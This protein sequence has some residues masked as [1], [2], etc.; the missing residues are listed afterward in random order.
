[1]TKDCEGS[2]ERFVKITGHLKARILRKDGSI[3]KRDLG[4]NTITDAAIA[5][6][7]NDWYDASKELTNMNYHA[8]G[9]GACAE[10]VTCGTSA[11][12]NEGSE[13]RVAGVKSKPTA[14]Q[15]RT[16]ATITCA[17]SGKTIKEWGVFDQQAVGGTAWSLRCFA[18]APITVGV[19]DSIEF[20]YTVTFTCVQG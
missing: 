8:W 17:G 2:E 19:G 3:E 5:F 11:L 4:K 9:T 15:L 6:L 12:V 13:T 18:S 14:P 1:M 10:P 16:V 20:T 7:V